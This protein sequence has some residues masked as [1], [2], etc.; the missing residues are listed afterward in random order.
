MPVKVGL[1]YIEIWKSMLEDS[2]KAYEQEPIEKGQIVFY[3]PSYFT[4]WSAKYG[5][6]P[7]REVIVG[8]SGKP[9][10]INRGF[11]S[12]CSEHQLYYYPRM[13][14]PLE[15]KVLVYECFANAGAFGYSIEERWELAQRVI[16]YAM[17]DFPGIQ[18]YLC[19]AHPV[20]DLD[21]EKIRDRAKFDALLKE[22]AENTPNCH[23]IDL[24]NYEPMKSKDIFIEDGVHFNAEGYKIYAELFRE[25]LKDE[26]EK[27]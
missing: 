11:G 17:T 12:S 16:A 9:C 27:F 25:A 26:L 8:K 14:R 23:F 5:E 20:R 6:K 24:M 21:E 3:G 4:R 15:P 13:V 18:V 19:G 10:A 1:R 22:F 7:L 2:V